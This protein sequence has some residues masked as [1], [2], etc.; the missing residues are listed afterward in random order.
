MH[1]K[2]FILLL[3]SIFAGENLGVHHLG[4]DPPHIKVHH[5]GSDPPHI[6]VH[7]LGSD[8]PH[9]RGTSLRK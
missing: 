3:V 8:P 5:L 7:H 1:R 9:I 2:D 4:S 6:K